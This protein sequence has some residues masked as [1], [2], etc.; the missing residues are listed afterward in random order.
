MSAHAFV[1]CRVRGPA[2]AGLTL[3]P[4]AIMLSLGVIY[5][6]YHHLPGF[7][8]VLTGV[9]AAGVGLTLSMGVKA[10]L[11][12]LR[13][14]MAVALAA[15]AFVGMAILRWPLWLVLAG[16]APSAWPGTGPASGKTERRVDAANGG[17]LLQLIVVFGSLIALFRWQ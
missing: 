16:L 8:S 13:Q 6:H 1:D 17:T 11:D 14:P 4:L 7:Q 10:G 5:F 12:I 3:V 2:L 9:V 15:A